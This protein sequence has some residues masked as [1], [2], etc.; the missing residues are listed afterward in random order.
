[1]ISFLAY[2]YGSPNWTM[3][4][5]SGHSCFTPQLASGYV[6]QGDFTFPVRI[7]KL[8]ANPKG[9]PDKQEDCTGATL[10]DKRP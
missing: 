5:L 6:T 8:L 7:S 4:G 10:S 9:T 2:A 3:L 1:M